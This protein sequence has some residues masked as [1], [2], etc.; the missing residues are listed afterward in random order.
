METRLTLAVL[1]RLLGEGCDLVGEF[2]DVVFSPRSSRMIDAR[3]CPFMPHA[4]A[5]RTTPCRG[6]EP[7]FGTLAGFT[8]MARMTTVLS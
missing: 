2:D 5:H 8:G 7:Q 6:S 3:A 1:Q 4:G